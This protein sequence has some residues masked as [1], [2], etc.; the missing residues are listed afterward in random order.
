MQSL[1]KYGFWPAS[2]SNKATTAVSMKLLDWLEA[3]ML[4]SHV[5]VQG[6]CRALMMKSKLTESQV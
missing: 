2:A 3:L 5:S 6:F 1:V 4:E